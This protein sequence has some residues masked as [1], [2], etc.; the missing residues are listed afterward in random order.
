MKMIIDRRAGKDAL[1]QVVTQGRERLKQGFY[2]I[3][4]PEGTR[5]A[6]GETKRYKAGR[7]LPGHPR[8]LSGCA[9]R[10]RC[11]GTA[12]RARPS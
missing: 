12:G 1:D 5:V 9:G 4:F 3:I 6:P 7:R 2:V 10:P 11:R 8:R